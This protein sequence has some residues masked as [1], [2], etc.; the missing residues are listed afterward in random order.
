MRSVDR[1]RPGHQAS[2][3]RRI[4]SMSIWSGELGVS[5]LGYALPLKTELGVSLQSRPR[6]LV[7][8]YMMMI[9]PRC[10]FA[11]AHLLTLHTQTQNCLDDLSGDPSVSIQGLDLFFLGSLAYARFAWKQ[12]VRSSGTIVLYWRVETTN[13]QV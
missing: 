11:L 3:A 7:C 9:F 10:T 2:A 12:T 4:Q 1:H 5:L 6:L 13:D 8:Y